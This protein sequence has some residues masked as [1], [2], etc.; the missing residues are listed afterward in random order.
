MTDK[1]LIALI[2]KGDMSAFDE[3]TK[4][5][6]N[7]VVNI[8]YSLLSDR[9]DA[10]DAAQEV[11]IKIY[12]NVSGFRGDS[13]VSTWVFR[14]TQ[15]VC[16]DFLRK[17]KAA[18]TVQSID[19]D[20]EDEPKLEIADETDSPEQVSEKN[21]RVRVLRRAIS[22]L[23]ENQRTVLTLFDI[24]G[25]SYEEISCIVKCPIGTVKSRLYR[26]RESLRKILTENKE[27]FL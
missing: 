17:R 24:E 7:R 16:R 2:K 5:Y 6:Q 21:E 15:N 10:L 11:F 22:E 9:E 8:A 18:P 14:I 25:M 19:N 3:F 12:R 13:S 1:E 27:L 26:A 4:M 20:D 23:E